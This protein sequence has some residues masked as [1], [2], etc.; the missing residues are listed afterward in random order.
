MGNLPANI[1]AK[2]APQQTGNPPVPLHL[3]NGANYKE[4][5]SKRIKR[6][7]SRNLRRVPVGI[8]LLCAILLVGI[9]GT[10]THYAKKQAETA[11]ATFGEIQKGGADTRILAQAAEN[12]SKVLWYGQHAWVWVKMLDKFNI[13]VGKPITAAVE[14]FNYGKEPTLVRARIYVEAAPMIRGAL[15]ERIPETKGI[16]EILLAPS[17]GTKEFAIELPRKVL[18][19]EDYRKIMDGTIDVLAYGR[20]EY[21]NIHDP[22]KSMAN[23]SF[24]F[25]R[26]KDGAVSACPNPDEHHFT[27][28]AY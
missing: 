18:T 26:M 11:N 24:C 27:N 12:E 13:Q 25:Y 28:W 23:S 6:Y 4:P 20:I 2:H 5:T 9:T 21:A 19:Q 10:Y 7:C 15:Q 1:N 14:V 17:E 8:E 22:V 16:R 3:E